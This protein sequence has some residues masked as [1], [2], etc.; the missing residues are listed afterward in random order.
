MTAKQFCVMTVGRSGSTALMNY[1]QT[2]DD[3]ALPC[4]EIDCVD[5]ELVHPKF[6]AQYQAAYSK[7]SGELVADNDALINTFF[8]R[9]ESLAYVGFKSMPNRHANLAQWLNRSDVQMIA[10]WREDVA[11]TV[12]SFMK[13][14]ETGSWRRDGATGADAKWYFDVQKHGEMA[15]NNLAY[16]L[17][18]NAILKNAPNAIKLSY[19]A[20]CD[21][22]F[23]HPELNQFFN[24]T[25][26]INNP[27]PPTSAE[28]YVEN[29][30]EFKQF[31]AEATQK[32][33]QLQQK[34]INSKTKPSSSEVMELSAI[35]PE[36]AHVLGYL[37]K[38]ASVAQKRATDF[39]DIQALCLFI[40]YPRSGHSIV[41]ALLDAHPEICIAQE[42]DIT[43]CLRAGMS[44]NVMYHLMTENSRIFTEQGKRW[45]TYNYEVAGQWLGKTPFLKVI[46]DKKGGGLSRAIAQSPAILDVI[47][48]TFK[49]PLKFIH[50]TRN[51][52]DNV[53]T[54]AAKQSM[55]LDQAATL[56]FN[57][58]NTAAMVKTKLAHQELCEISHE[59]FIANPQ[60]VLDQL[61]QFLGLNATPE[62][63]SACAG[64]VNK[65]PHQ[66][67]HQADWT[68]AQ[69]DKMTNTMQQFDFLK[70]YQFD[71]E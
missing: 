39:K 56:Y 71:G 5:N 21:T 57:M 37:E 69:K 38:L 15:L 10:L 35:M 24:R 40:G 32:L 7:L 47:R 19:E 67:R 18:S 9:H 64:I 33:E 70:H 36:L 26:K 62:Y 53:A 8:K 48:T 54:I 3:I 43:R 68:A 12:A 45:N 4:K 25:V 31:I 59:A 17:K 6:S 28:Q 30:A 13:A 20:L 44:R 16:V 1:L 63:L 27:K 42:L 66:S 61:V 50:I 34:K 41:G 55:P 14:Q 22:Q 65:T 29:W 51:P 60:A 58:A 11:S 46:G 2:F 23:N 52:F 49:V